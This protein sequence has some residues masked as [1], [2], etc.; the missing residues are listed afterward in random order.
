[1]SANNCLIDSSLALYG[2]LPTYKVAK[3]ES[4]LTATDLLLVVL[5]VLIL[6]STA[7]ANASKDGISI[8]AN[9]K[10]TNNGA[11][12]GAKPVEEND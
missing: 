4:V 1:M 10:T 7:G 2:R 6:S 12:N 11:M 9:V 3:L 5:G 8:N